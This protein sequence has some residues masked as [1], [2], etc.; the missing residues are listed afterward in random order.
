MI[1]CEYGNIQISGLK[2]I[3]ETE[4]ASLIKGFKENGFT[5]D[6]ILELVDLA[7]MTEEE[8][9]KAN[10]EL[11]KAI[12]SHKKEF[13]E[14]VAPELVKA[15]SEIIKDCQEDVEEDGE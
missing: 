10:K 12:K 1:K 5:K 11:D 7:F 2:P 15:L 6:K 9:R 3:I 13:L 14:N 8:V 4:L